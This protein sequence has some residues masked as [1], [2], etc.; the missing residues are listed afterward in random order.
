MAYG[1]TSVSALLNQARA[2]LKKQQG[3]EEEVAAYEYDLSPK[4]QAAYDKYSS[5]LDTRIKQVQASDP[6]KALSLQRKITGAQRTFTSSELTR[7][8]IGIAEGTGSKPAKLN[9]MIALYRRALEN[10][11]E[12]LAQRIQLQADNLQVQIQNEAMAGAGRG[13]GGGGSGDTT[14][15]GKGIKKDLDELKLARTRLEEN[16]RNGKVGE[17][18]YIDKMSKIMDGSD[19]ILKNAFTIDANGDVLPNNNGISIKEA[20]D[21][22]KDRVELRKNN[23]FQQLMGTDERVPFDIRRAQIN[24]A[25]KPTFNPVT[26][27]TEFKLN[28]VTGI[29]RLAELGAT[30]G[31]FNT[32]TNIDKAKY[33]AG[34][35][36]LGLP[37]GGDG[38]IDRGYKDAA[39]NEVGSSK[40]FLDNPDNPSY[41]YTQDKNNV[42][43][44]LDKDGNS[45]ILGDSKAG[46]DQIT[47]LKARLENPNISPQER[48]AI[49]SDIQ[50]V[51][52]DMVPAGVIE[53]IQNK[54]QD[55]ID[56]QNNIFGIEDTGKGLRKI[57]KEFSNDAGFVLDK[58]RKGLA[59]DRVRGLAT[60][61]GLASPFSGLAGLASGGLGAVGAIGDL[62]KKLTG[63]KAQAEAKAAADAAARAAEFQRNQQIYQQTLA[64][65]QAAQSAQLNQSVLGKQNQNYQQRSALNVYAGITD[66]A[67]RSQ[68]AV[69]DFNKQYGIGQYKLR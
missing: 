38:S 64:A 32:D 30:Q 59:I 52:T 33:E 31:A 15:Q 12:N 67:A 24:N 18:E 29:R 37:G 39:G 51:N 4:D 11:D 17:Q 14:D 47:A 66:P 19:N 26:G 36:K 35:K 3:L 2:A 21:L 49:M 61:L 34:F 10:G 1:N 57:G 16:F 60:G 7:E 13:G 27:E 56:A 9:K 68:A 63:M 55:Q 23:Q 41:A 6:S 8:S 25:F 65:Q 5:F 53:D 62:T 43:Y 54:S 28:N 44:A 50:K 20:A 46:S 40:F 58:A 45:V 22:Y 69:T 48:A 42:R